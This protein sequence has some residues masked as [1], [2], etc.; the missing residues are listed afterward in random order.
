M[1]K[2]F[3]WQD[4]AATAGIAAAVTSALVAY[5]GKREAGSAAAP[6][7]ATSHIA[8]GDESADID[9]VDV[10]HTAVG[11]LLHAGAMLM[12]S[13]VQ[14]LFASRL[15]KRTDVASNL[16]LGGATS[17]VAYVADYVVVPKRFTPG[18]ELRLSKP[19]LAAVYV[20]LAASLAAGLILTKRDEE[21]A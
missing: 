2:Q 15:Q 1:A 20:A 12:W 21:L 18:F 11:A 3:N 7:N 16:L 9:G 4:A 17:A 10:K 13:L 14:E 8:W 5:L 6:I 19:S